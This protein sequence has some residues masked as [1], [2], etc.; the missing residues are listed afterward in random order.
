MA[1][2]GSSENHE[3]RRLTQREVNGLADRCLSRGLTTL[4]DAPKPI[5]ADLLL[6][7]GCLRLLAAEHPGGVIIDVWREMP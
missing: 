2:D 7:S 4:W 6:C 3:I 1:E 5:K